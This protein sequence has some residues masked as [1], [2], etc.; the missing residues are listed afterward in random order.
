MKPKINPAI[1]KLLMMG[2]DIMVYILSSI[3]LFLG[4]GFLISEGKHSEAMAIGGAALVIFCKL[5]QIF[6]KLAGLQE[7][8]LSQ[9]VRKNV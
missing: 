6:Q 1:W 9:Y 7:E 8:R 3:T 2:L 4:L 5:D